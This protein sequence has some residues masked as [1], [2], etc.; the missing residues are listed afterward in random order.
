MTVRIS[1]TEPKLL[2]G[3]ISIRAYF[4]TPDGLHRMTMTWST[5]PGLKLRPGPVSDYRTQLPI[6]ILGEEL[7]DQ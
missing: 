3:W 4:R 2:Q 1:L 5:K 6:R 7:L